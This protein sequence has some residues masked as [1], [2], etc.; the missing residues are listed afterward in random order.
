[1]Q[2]TVTDLYPAFL[3]LS[4]IAI[5]FIGAFLS[6]ILGRIS[7]S[8]RDLTLVSATSLTLL[9]VG[10]L[11]PLQIPT[12]TASVSFEHAFFFYTPVLSIHPLSYAVLLI[13]I[14]VWMLASLYATRYMKEEIRTNRFYFF[15]LLSLAADLG[16][17][18]SGDFLTLYL[19]FEFLT[20]SAFVLL[21]HRHAATLAEWSLWDLIHTGFSVFSGNKHYR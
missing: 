6:Y 15:W 1:M 21:A 9:V 13:S 8:L 11:I 16:V 2:M 19:F 7:L 14:F 5:P 3:L 17:L 10:I 4:I 12:L 20:L 18:L